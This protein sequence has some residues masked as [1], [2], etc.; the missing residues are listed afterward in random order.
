MVGRFFLFF[1]L[2]GVRTD[3]NVNEVL[4]LFLKF[5]K[6]KSGEGGQV[7]VAVNDELELL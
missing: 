6:K 7:R 3:L 1:F 4:K 2:G 5:Q